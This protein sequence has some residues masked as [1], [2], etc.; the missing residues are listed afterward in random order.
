MAWKTDELFKY[1]ASKFYT[2]IL[3][4]NTSKLRAIVYEIETD[5]KLRIE[6]H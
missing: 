3:N 5:L 6:S 1:S 2:F 4:S